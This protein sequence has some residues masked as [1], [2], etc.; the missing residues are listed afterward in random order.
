MIATTAMG[1]ALMRYI[2]QVPVDKIVER[3]M[4]VVKEVPVV[5]YV[6]RVVT[7]EVPV[8]QVVER[9]VEV[10]RLSFAQKCPDQVGGSLTKKGLH[11]ELKFRGV[12]S[13]LEGAPSRGCEGG[14]CVC[15]P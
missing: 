11:K 10:R 3:R 2:F 8:V 13:G 12:F 7:K 14:S 1:K 9:V 4:E 15:P 5:R 6:D